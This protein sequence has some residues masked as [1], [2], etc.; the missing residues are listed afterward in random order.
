MAKPSA[1]IQPPSGVTRPYGQAVKTSPFHGGN[2]SSNLGRVTKE[3]LIVSGSYHKE[4]QLSWLEHLPYKQG[5]TGSSPVVSTNKNETRTRVSF[6]YGNTGLSLTMSMKDAMHPRT[7]AKSL[8]ALIRLCKPTHFAI[9]MFSTSTSQQFPPTS[10]N[11]PLGWLFFYD[12][13]LDSTA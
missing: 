1:E 4:A 13:L 8:L 2:P 5:V 9:T 3:P 11:H 10:V 7:S 12:I 6:F